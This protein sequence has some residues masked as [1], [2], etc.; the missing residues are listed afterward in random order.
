MT[1]SHARAAVAAALLGSLLCAAAPLS[2]QARRADVPGWVGHAASFGTNSL[3]G[4]LTA[5]LFQLARGGS[6][7]DGFTRGALG[8]ALVYGGKRLA[9]ERFDGAGFL[10]REVAAVGSSVVR[11]ASEGRGSLSRLMLP[12]GPVRLNVSTEDGFRVQPKL[13][14]AAAVW[15]GYALATPELEWDAR[16]SLSAGTPVFRAENVVLGADAE[17]EGGTT[18]ITRAG[19]VFLSD[20]AGVDVEQ[21]EVHERIHALQYDQFFW[22]W[23]DPAEDWLVDRLPG[24]RAL[25]RWVDLNASYLVVSGFSEVFKNYDDRPWELEAFFL[26]R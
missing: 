8:G 24:G 20:L 17:R 1:S 10:G 23:T 6:F 3:L 11:N 13:D 5:G 14:L 15:T 12:L 25:N 26:A 2:A 18:G 22:T 7:Q 19:V 16:A 21:N 9:S 4:G